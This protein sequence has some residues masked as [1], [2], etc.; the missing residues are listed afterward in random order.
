MKKHFL[1]TKYLEIKAQ[2]EDRFSKN[3]EETA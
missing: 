1:D 3:P 2:G